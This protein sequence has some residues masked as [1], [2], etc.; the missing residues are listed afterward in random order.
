MFFC[1]DVNIWKQVSILDFHVQ[2]F[3]VCEWI[4]QPISEK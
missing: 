4:V 1:L 2:N 3:D